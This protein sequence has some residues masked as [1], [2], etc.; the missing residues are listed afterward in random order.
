MAYET[1]PKNLSIHGLE[2]LLDDHYVWL[3]LSFTLASDIGCSLYIETPL[4][5]VTLSQ[6]DQ[7]VPIGAFIIFITL[8][9][10]LL[11]LTSKIRF[12]FFELTS[13]TT[14]APLFISEFI[15]YICYQNDI[16][17]YHKE[18]DIKLTQEY[19]EKTSYYVRDHNL[20]NYLFL[21]E[22]QTLHLLLTEFLATE[23]QRKSKLLLIFDTGLLL[24]AYPWLPTSSLN[25]LIFANY[26]ISPFWILVL[27]I[28]LMYWA[29]YGHTD[30]WVYVGKQ[31]A[32]RINSSKKNP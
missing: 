26:S 4:L 29:T 2:R 14:Y 10:I 30:K 1:D 21:N 13:W 8:F 17:S 28:A 6:L 24:A 7:K 32:Q 3:L 19:K 23:R 22:N 20:Q 5:S 9:S 25:I 16:K 18:K 12:F 27:G 15:A 11:T 31:T